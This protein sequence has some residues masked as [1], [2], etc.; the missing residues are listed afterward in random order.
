MIA[1]VGAPA[2]QAD[3]AVIPEGIYAGGK[4]P[5]RNGR[6]CRFNGSGRVCDRTSRSADHHGCEWCGCSD[7]G[8]GAGFFL[9]KQGSGEGEIWKNIPLA[10]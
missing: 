6:G 7:Y 2:L 3:A 5:W 10:M 4:K 8:S 1:L 9:V